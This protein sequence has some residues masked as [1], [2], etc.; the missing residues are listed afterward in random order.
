VSVTIKKGK[1]EWLVFADSY[2]CEFLVRIE[3]WCQF[4]GCPELR[5]WIKF[6]EGRREGVS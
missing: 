5:N 6:L 1:P 2:I 4:R 3:E